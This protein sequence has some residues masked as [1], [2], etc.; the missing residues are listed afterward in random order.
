MVLTRL[1]AAAGSLRGPRATRISAI[2][3]ACIATLQLLSLAIGR[4]LPLPANPAQADA[5]VVLGGDPQRS[6][7]GVELYK[8]GLAPQLWH[9][10]AYI[11]PGQKVSIAHLAIR[12]AIRDGVPREATSL[13]ASR[14]TWEDGEAIAGLV[15]ERGVRR[16]LV[17]TTWSHSRRA[18]CVLQ[19][20]LAGTGVELHYEPPPAEM[21]DPRT[22]WL[23]GKER[24]AVLREVVA[25]P[26][27][28]LRYGLNPF[29][30]T[31]GR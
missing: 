5:I 1:R 13:L 29:D 23:G 22:W 7:Y 11:K 28:W 25:I 20:H 27:Y 17:V 4:L 6:L 2:V 31:A 14:T 30:C 8:H 15:R 16:L 9:T 24:M 21:F 3:I 18:L 12:D 19:H 10:G 26:Y